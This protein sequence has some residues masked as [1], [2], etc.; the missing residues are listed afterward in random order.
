MWWHDAVIYQ[1]YPR[2]FADADGNGVGDL[3]GLRSR[4]EHLQWLGVDALWVS[5]IFRSPM[6]DFGY[7]VSD[8]CDIDPIFGT[9]ADFDGLLEEAHSRDL[10]VLLDLVPN[11]TSIEHPWFRAHPDRYVWRD[12]RGPDGS[13]P[14][15]NWVRAFPFPPALPAWTRDQDRGRWYLHL[16]LPEQPDLDW[17]NPD[18]VEAM[19][20]V[21]RFWFDRG[22]DGWR[23]DVAHCIG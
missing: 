3:P 4:L 8:Y 1:I 19:Q 9:L 13:E 16:F 15:N 12:G 11:H 14:P 22:V 21:I 10:R 2:S 5:P 20:E 18:V 7:D 17:N 23:I 6:A